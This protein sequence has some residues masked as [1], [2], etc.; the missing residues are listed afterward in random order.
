MEWRWVV[1]LTSSSVAGR[2]DRCATGLTN[3]VSEGP[4]ECEW[5]GSEDQEG[6]DDGGFHVSFQLR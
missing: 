5:S 6:N 1:Y 2:D 3:P 4:G